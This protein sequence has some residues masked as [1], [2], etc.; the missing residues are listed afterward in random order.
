MDVLCNC[1]KQMLGSK[2]YVLVYGDYRCLVMFFADVRERGGEAYLIF[3][4]TNKAIV[5]AE[6][7]AVSSVLEQRAD[8]FDLVDMRYKNENVGCEFMTYR[9]VRNEKEVLD[10]VM[11][12]I[13]GTACYM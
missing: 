5:V 12:S 9:I 6:R 2:N 10:E 11:Y 4:G 3:T 8:D 13:F 1:L 7:G